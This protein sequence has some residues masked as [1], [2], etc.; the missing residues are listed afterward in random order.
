MKKL[1]IV[2]LA[3][4]MA[5]TV[6]AGCSSGG[7]T[8]ATES[9]AAAT[10]PAAGADAETS[11][12]AAGG[13]EM[14][15]GFSF[16]SKETTIYQAFED[17]AVK[18]G[19]AN[20]PKISYS[21]TVADADVSKQANNIK[22]LIAKKP[23]AIVMM[24]QDSKAI[25]S[26]IKEAHA[27]GIPVITYNRAATPDA[28]EK[29]DAHIGL[30]AVDQAYTTTKYLIE[31]MQKDGVEPKLIN[32]MG[33]LVDENAIN[34]DKG[35]KQACEEMGI[36]PLQDVPSE[37]DPDKALSG[38]TAALQAH[39]DANGVFVASDMLMPAVQSALERVNKWAPYGEENHMYIGTQD[40]APN[41]AA[42]LEQGYNDVST[43]FD[44]DA[45]TVALTE[46]L[47]KIHNG[48]DLGNE[49]ILVKGKVC[50]PN[51]LDECQ[52][53]W[54]FVYDE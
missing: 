24:P 51:N 41:G 40:V 39:P 31:L 49:E 19:E 14:N 16:A 15:V 54:G 11:G 42:M 4:V 21:F 13:D 10:E 3:V 28:D 29:A 45:M 6:F 33:D 8:A 32:V 36:T 2:V 37:W 27:A 12:A 34:R 26:S 18:Q 1:L 20:D 17:Y 7:G 44:I 30:D 22:D 52:N 5:M 46:A 23:D 50:T 47:T 35:F 43:A 48:E 25:V 9:P 53:V 38:L